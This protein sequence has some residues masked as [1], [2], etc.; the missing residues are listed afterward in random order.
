[1][2]SDPELG[3]S[4]ACA[5]PG[6]GRDAFRLPFAVT[7][8]GGIRAPIVLTN[9]D[10][11]DPIFHAT[12]NRLHLLSDPFFFLLPPRKVPCVGPT[13]NRRLVERPVLKELEQLRLRKDCVPQRERLAVP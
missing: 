6:A 11:A 5:C 10:R 9:A 4:K 12:Q 7:N 3:T 8:G 1:M 13:N 2:G